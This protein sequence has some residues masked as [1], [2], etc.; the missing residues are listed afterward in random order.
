MVES[1][2]SDLFATRLTTLLCRK[3]S[4]S[5]TDEEEVGSQPLL[6]VSAFA[7]YVQNHQAGLYSWQNDIDMCANQST[8]ESEARDTLLY[9]TSVKRTETFFLTAQYSHPTCQPLGEKKGVESS[10]S[11][12]SGE[13]AQELPRSSPVD[14]AHVSSVATMDDDFQQ[15][16]LEKIL[17]EQAEEDERR[18]MAQAAREQ[19]MQQ[20][21][22]AFSREHLAACGSILLLAWIA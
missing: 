1:V 8:K 15:Q 18:L 21:E 20:F 7:Q 14:R 6:A 19:E 13:P 16:Q 2:N 4:C 9:S 17:K 10:V 11:E 3:L 22:L 5:S 12:H